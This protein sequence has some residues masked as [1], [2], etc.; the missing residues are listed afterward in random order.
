MLRGALEAAQAG[1]PP[2]VVVHG[3]PGIG[4]TRTV[5][6]FARESERAGSAVLWGTCYQGGITYP[7]GPWAQALG[8]FLEGIPGEHVAG[9]LGPDAAALARLLPGRFA[10]AP[11]LPPDQGRLRLYEAVVRCLQSIE[12]TPVLV[13]DDLQWAD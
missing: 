7:Y 5:A 11:A 3:E 4:K 9:V 13:L 10:D 12:R 6:E 1:A 8:G 2:V